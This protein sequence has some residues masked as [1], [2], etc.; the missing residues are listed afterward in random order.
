Y[1]MA[2]LR[3]AFAAA[4]RAQLIERMLHAEPP[5]PRQLDGQ[6]PRDL[7]TVILKAIAKEPDRRYQ[8]AGEL[9]EDLQRFLADRPIQARR[10]RWPE[11]FGRWCRRNPVVA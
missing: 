5:R 4:E 8:T 9:A 6:I 2:T 7:E 1:E 11:R 3:P 10:S